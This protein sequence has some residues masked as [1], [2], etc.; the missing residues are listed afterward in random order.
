VVNDC[1]RSGN[2]RTL[3][4]PAGEHYNGAQAERTVRRQ[5]VWRS[6]T[7]SAPPPSP[8]FDDISQEQFDRLLRWLDPDREGAGIKYESI[9]K[10]LI[11]IFV[12]RGSKTPEELA[13]QTIN[14][15][16]RKLPEIQAE[17]VGEPAHYFCGVAS[18]VFR[19]SLKKDR[20]RATRLPPL[21]TEDEVDEQDYACLE[22]CIAKLSG[23]DRDLVLGYYQEEKH[24]KIDHRK[25]LAEQ[26]GIGLNA[27]RIRACRIRASLQE[28][29][30][31]C[32]SE[33]QQVTKQKPAGGHI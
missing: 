2:S 18:N 7:L 16:A 8:G 30:E 1:I 24:A 32:R 25:K 3:G 10:R 20:T 5:N 6:S 26:L 14:R 33:A 31:L 22:K 9:R 28:C 13:D 15:V 29:V 19:E 23:Y 17:Y 21:A 4:F 27:L 11:K 12:C